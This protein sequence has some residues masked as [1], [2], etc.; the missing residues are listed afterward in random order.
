V[1]TPRAFVSAREGLG[2]ERL[3]SLIG[4]HVRPS[5]LNLAG[6]PQSC[7]D[8]ALSHQRDTRLTA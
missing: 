2:L 6:A 4:E 7:A 8:N 3:R 5:A 1:R